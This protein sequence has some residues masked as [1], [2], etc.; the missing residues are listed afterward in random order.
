[1]EA[2][3]IKH[4]EIIHRS[5]IACGKKELPGYYFSLFSE[6]LGFFSVLLP[7]IH[8]LAGSS[9]PIY[10]P[11]FFVTDVLSRSTFPP[12]EL[13]QWSLTEISGSSSSY[14]LSLSFPSSLER[15]RLLLSLSLQRSPALFLSSLF[16]VFTVQLAI[17][18]SENEF[19]LLLHVPIKS[20]GNKITTEWKMCA[21]CAWAWCHFHAYWMWWHKIVNVVSVACSP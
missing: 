15:S 18:W 11:D 14:F 10:D 9:T 3:W 20:L 13:D 7:S 4:L 12:S 19:F 2:P 16:G 17:C 6:P 5:K 1:M 21:K 8:K